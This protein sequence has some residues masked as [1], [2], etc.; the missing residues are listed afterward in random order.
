MEMTGFADGL[1][2]ILK[3]R[4]QRWLSGFWPKQ[5]AI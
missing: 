1:G 5:Q 3:D 4:N 2:E